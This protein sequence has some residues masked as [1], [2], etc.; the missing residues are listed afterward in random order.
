MFSSHLLHAIWGFVLEETFK[1]FLKCVTSLK[2]V[3]RKRHLTAINVLSNSYRNLMA[4]LPNI[5]RIALPDVEC[6]TKCYP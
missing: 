3:V 5:D 4:R 6:E 1:T 2:K